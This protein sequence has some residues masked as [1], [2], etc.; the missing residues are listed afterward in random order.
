MII[1]LKLRLSCSVRVNKINLVITNLK[2]IFIYFDTVAL[3]GH[4]KS[5]NFA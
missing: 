1:L 2:K 5:E 4:V 3:I